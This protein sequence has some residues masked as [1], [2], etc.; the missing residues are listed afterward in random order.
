MEDSDGLMT[1]SFLD[2][3]DLHNSTFIT[4]KI[5]CPASPDDCEPLPLKRLL[6]SRVGVFRE[7]GP[8]SGRGEQS[9]GEAHISGQFIIVFGGLSSGRI[10]RGDSPAT[11]RHHRRRGRAAQSA[12]RS[13]RLPYAHTITRET[14]PS[15]R[16]IRLLTT[17]RATGPA[18]NETSFF[19]RLAASP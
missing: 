18:I 16:G 3:D 7:T 13:A 8:A 9:L 4:G 12:Q 2:N 14:E 10:A 6:A 5:I 11:R 15:S 19:P 17:Q 1:A